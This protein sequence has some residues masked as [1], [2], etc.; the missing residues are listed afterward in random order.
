MFL[1]A[2][3]SPDGRTLLSVG[4]SNKVYFHCISGGARLTFTPI[5]TLVIPAPDVIPFGFS[6]SSLVASF[7]TAFSR[8][9]SKF[10]VASQEGVVA[11]W[12]VRSTKPIKVFHTD[13]SRGM[14]G[15]ERVLPGNGAASGWLSD[16]PWEWTRGTRAPGWCVRNVKF[17][18]GDGARLGR[19]VM[20]FTEHTS[21][22]HVV[23][24]LTF[25]THDIIRM[26][27]VVRPESRR[28]HLRQSS[29]P[30]IIVSSPDANATTSSVPSSA[31]QQRRVRRHL[32]RSMLPVSNTRRTSTASMSTEG[33][34]SSARR[35]ENL[36]VARSAVAGQ[37]S[38][39]SSTSASSGRPG[40][41]Q[42][43]N[44]AFIIP[45]SAYSAPPSIGDSTWRTLNDEM[46]I[47]PFSRRSVLSGPDAR[48][49]SP[50]LTSPPMPSLQALANYVLEPH[51]Y[52][53]AHDHVPEEIREDEGALSRR[54]RREESALRRGGVQF[55]T[56][57][58]EDEESGSSSDATEYVPSGP[59]GP[60]PVGTHRRATSADGIVVVPDLGDRDVET[61]VHTL[62]AVH[63]IPSRFGPRRRRFNEFAERQG[64]MDLDEGYDDED[65]TETDRD[66]NTGST[67]ADYDYP[68]YRRRSRRRRRFSIPAAEDNVFDEAEEDNAVIEEERMDVDE[69]NH[70][71]EAHDDEIIEDD[72]DIDEED[73]D[74][75]SNAN[76]R[77]AS[78]TLD[79][80]PMSPTRLGAI[81]QASSSAGTS[82]TPTT[83]TSSSADRESKAEDSADYF[84]DDAE[85]AGSFYSGFSSSS[86]PKLAYYDDFD[87]AG[88][89]FDP[90]GERMYVAGTFTG[91][92]DHPALRG[93]GSG[94]GN[95][96]FSGAF[97]SPAIGNIGGHLGTV[98]EW[99]VSGADKRFWVDEGWM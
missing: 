50:T 48:E 69:V 11:V 58:F 95:G 65:G 29:A 54:I 49:T 36:R 72:V 61:E 92:S 23:D 8:D 27:T 66:T 17:N 93:G 96:L 6:T 14:G 5:T 1:V 4:D 9:G 77:S 86:M 67:H 13:K 62:L 99:G 79:S 94:G 26:P 98:V 15:R 83:T 56:G 21:L 59:G 38:S 88:I 45:A 53:E 63:G 43:L 2:S 30:S 40:V 76:S 16:D 74:C 70:H 44:D 91:H 82:T 39:S 35:P 33:S 75:G 7:S 32:A 47:R 89:C 84:F 41:V 3:I 64:N 57:L 52:R 34:S 25:E 51:E 60:G 10:A 31:A 20:A 97:G 71:D 90:Y 80:E 42:A 68:I 81:L 78:P 22:V 73:T 12:D 28:R 87:L 18:G 24:A 55:G 46:P 19:E 37:S 85:E